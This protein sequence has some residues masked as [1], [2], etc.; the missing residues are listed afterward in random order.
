MHVLAF[1]AV[2]GS[3]SARKSLHGGRLAGEQAMLTSCAD[4][5]F[6]A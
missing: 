4:A 1:A 6:P 3:A 2:L 5:G